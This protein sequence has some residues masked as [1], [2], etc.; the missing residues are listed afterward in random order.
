MRENGK[1]QKIAGAGRSLNLLLWFTFSV[2]ALILVVIF[3]AVQG[4]L[5]GSRYREQTL[6]L[7]KEANAEMTEVLGAAEDV[8][9]SVWRE[10]RA[11]EEEYE[12][13]FRLMYTDGRSVFSDG[14]D[15]ENYPDIAVTLKNIFKGDATEVILNEGSTLAYATVVPIG[16]QPCFL[17]LTSSLSRLNSL[18]GSLLWLSLS[19]ALFSVVLAFVASG[20]VAMLITKPVTEVTEQAKEMARGHY[21]LNFKHD[22]FCQ[23]ISE[24]AG[25]LDYARREISK[26]DAMQKEL[27]ANV[28]HDFKTPLTMIKAYASM[29]REISGDNK[30]KRDAHAQIILEECDRLTALVNDVLDLSKLRAGALKE[31]ATTFNLSEL[32]YKIAGRFAYLCE[33]QGYR[34]ETQIGED[35]YAYAVRERVE[36]V[37]YNLIGNA[38]NYTGADKT[39]KLRLFAKGMYVRFEVED[40][41]KGIPEEERDTIWDRYYRSSETHKRP[42]QGTGL[43]LSIVKSILIS[44]DCP[45]G[46][47]SELDHGSTF[48][49][50]FP[51]PPE[52]RPAEEQA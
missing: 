4:L 21:D 5:V 7:M 23:E 35:L 17:Y 48:W 32:V 34:L 30:Q 19:T 26:A 43:G 1:K 40:S 49:A 16:G 29:I 47:E 2:F 9:L 27:I 33:T 36:Q 37:V 50:E 24:L 46:V 13:R 3:M 41:G 28:S 12:V 52:D 51:S 25:A 44:Q 10:L 22:Y 14:P 11:V 45:F 38:V 15:D 6:S 31:P 20:F 42:V 18:E 39:V 8:S